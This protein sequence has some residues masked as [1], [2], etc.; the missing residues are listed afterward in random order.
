MPEYYF[1]V[2]QGKYSNGL[3]EVAELPDSSAACSH[4]LTIWSDLARGIATE[5]QSEPEWRMEVAD[6]IR[7][8]PDQVARAG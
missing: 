5:L 3:G 1:R 2:P 8:G 7:Q 4:A 6:V